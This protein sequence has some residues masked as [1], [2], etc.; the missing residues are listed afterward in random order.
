MLKKL[1]LLRVTGDFINF[2]LL[3]VFTYHWIKSLMEKGIVMF[4]VYEY[5][6]VMAMG[7]GI[8][9]VIGFVVCTWRLWKLT[10]YPSETE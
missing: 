9:L 4:P 10:S 2:S 8:L 6:P 3:G 7:E 5:D 1:K